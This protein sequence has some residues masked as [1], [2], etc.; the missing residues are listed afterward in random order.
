MKEKILFMFIF[1][2]FKCLHAQSTTSANAATINGS[3]TLQGKGNVMFTFNERYDG[4]EGSRFFFDD[5]YHTGELWLT[6]NRHY[7]NQYKYKFDQLAGTVQVQQANGKEILI[8]IEE[9]LTFQMFIDDKSVTFFKTQLPNAE[10]PSIV[11]VVY[12]SSN[13]TFFRDIKKKLVRE[14]E[15]S[16]YS[17]GKVYDKI[18]NDYQYYLSKKDALAVQV[19]PNK[20]GFIKVLPD[21]EKEIVRLFKTKKFEDLTVS[22]LA[23]LMQKLDTE[24]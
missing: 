19:K 11:Q 9:I 5:E 12:R 14:K 16:A 24:N 21:K 6:N 18:I 13:M 20:K 23:D 22:K 10:S 3:T 8:T 7:T 17:D 15:S 2:C 1:L 4:I